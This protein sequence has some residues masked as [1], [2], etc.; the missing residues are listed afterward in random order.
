MGISGA[1]GSER[2]GR[3]N[4]IRV[5]RQD[6]RLLQALPIIAKITLTMCIATALATPS[7]CESQPGIVTVWRIRRGQTEPRR[8]V[9]E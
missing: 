2:R 3:I 4:A 5:Q 8:H 7:V 6:Y 1:L 9:I